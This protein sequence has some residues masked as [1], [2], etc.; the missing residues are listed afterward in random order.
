MD[1]Q[2]FIKETLTQIVNGIED[3]RAVEGGDGI[4]GGKRFKQ[5]H[6]APGIMQDVSGALFTAIELDVAV[7]TK[8]GVEGGGGLRIAVANFGAKATSGN[9]TASRVKFTIPMRF[10]DY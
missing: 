3:A 7:T 1:L 2:S 10:K 5:I 4:A 8:D 6:P 9:E